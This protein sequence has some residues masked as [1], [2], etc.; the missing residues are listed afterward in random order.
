[1]T[2]H[3][4]RDFILNITF[5]IQPHFHSLS[6]SIPHC[7]LVPVHSH[8]GNE[9]LEIHFKSGLG[10][11][12]WDKTFQLVQTETEGRKDDRVSGVTKNLSRRR[13]NG[14]KLET[15]GSFNMSFSLCLH[16]CRRIFH[17]FSLL[18]S[19]IFLLLFKQRYSQVITH[20]LLDEI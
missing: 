3:A 4:I 6:L 13:K 17:P 14:K 16:Y 5:W 19:L 18:P 12:L 15:E 11:K 2:D 20:C 1:M 8:P 7:I 9:R 10:T